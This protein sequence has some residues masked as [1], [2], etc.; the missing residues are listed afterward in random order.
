MIQNDDIN[1]GPSIQYLFGRWKTILG[2]GI[3]FALIGGTL[4]MIAAPIWAAKATLILPPAEGAAASVLGLG[5]AKPTAILQGVL[6]SRPVREAVGK[7]GK[8]SLRDLDGMIAYEVDDEAGQVTFVIQNSDKK[9]GMLMVDT[10]LSS[11]EKTRSSIS[12]GMAK[13]QANL[14]ANVANEKQ[15]ALDQAE[16]AVLAF[17]KKAKSVPDP[18]KPFSGA[19]YL[20]RLKESEFSLEAVKRQI[21]QVRSTLGRQAAASVDIPL[22][23][24]IE[25]MAT[26][27]ASISWRDRLVQLEYELQVA[28]ITKGP[29]SPDVIRLKEQITVTK[30]R[31]Q[32]EVSKYLQGLSAGLDRNVAELEAKKALLQQEVE[33]L[34]EMS[35]VAPTE[36]A[37]VQRLLRNIRLREEEYKAVIILLNEAQLRAQVDKLEWTILTPTYVEDVPTN[38]RPVRTAFSWFAVGSIFAGIL[39]IIQRARRTKR[40]KA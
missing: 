17:Q 9:A 38:K 14:L 21:S 5:G 37:I 20:A 25:S 40:S 18:S 7:V 24:P 10:A 36:D 16:Q 4:T 12:T 11:L 27:G 39:L 30:N 2:T 15:K 8:V 19:T 35:E 33:Y 28:E 3:I 32:S 13:R 31:A 1:L 29:Q 6:N 26:P 22:I 34:K 23:S